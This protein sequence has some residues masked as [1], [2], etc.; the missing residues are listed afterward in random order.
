MC[1]SLHATPL[2]DRDAE[3]SHLS[4]VS[5]AC[6]CSFLIIPL[7]AIQRRA[8]LRLAIPVHKLSRGSRGQTARNRNSA[9][10]RGVRDAAFVWKLRVNGSNLT[11]TDSGRARTNV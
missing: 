4:A 6:F 8:R 5:F 11:E 1:R 10:L 3:L 7:T 9:I 2:P